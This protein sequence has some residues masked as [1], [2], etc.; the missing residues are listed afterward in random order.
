MAVGLDYPQDLHPIAGV[1]IG[2]VDAGIRKTKGPDIALIEISAGSTIA[3][4]F[5]KNRARAAPVEIALQRMSENRNRNSGQVRALVI[6]SGNANAGLGQRGIRDSELVCELVGDSLKIES[7][8]VLPFST[9]VIGEPLPVHRFEK[10]LSACC[11]TKSADNWLHAARAIMTTDTVPKAVS[12]KVEFKDQGQITITGIAKGS[13]MIQPDMAT[14]LAFIATDAAVESEYLQQTLQ[15]TVNDSFNCISVDGDTSTNDSCV[16]IATGASGIQ[17]G[18]DT[19]SE[20]NHRFNKALEGILQ[21]LA[22]A[23]VRDGEGITKFVTIRVDG[24]SSQ[25]DCAKVAMTVANSPLVKT[26]LHASDPNWGRIYAAIGRSPV[27]VLDMSRLR[28]QVDDVEI[29]KNG[30]RSPNYS[31]PEAMNVMQKSEFMIRI[32]L[33]INSTTSATVW[34][35]DLS[36]EYVRINAEYRS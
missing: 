27:E 34:T 17:I 19:S 8:L 1:Q 23:I 6:N 29:V 24:G 9:G 26:A 3:A 12:K 15:S 36:Y 5:T 16:L 10:H 2:V 21:Q 4:T 33:G 18:H 13:G 25:S 28:I 31:E 20:V 14:M 7:E 30:E 35:T 22:Q 11:Q 32:D